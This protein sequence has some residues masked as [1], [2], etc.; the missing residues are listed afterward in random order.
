MSGTMKG[1]LMGL[2]GF[3][4]GLMVSPQRVE[5]QA[6]ALTGPLHHLGFAVKDADKAAR[7]FAELFEVKTPPTRAVRDIPWGPD[8]PGKKMHVKV[9]SFMH[10]GIMWEMLEGVDGESPWGNHIAKHGESLH[11]I[12]IAV[13]NVPAARQKL[14][15]KGGKVTQEFSPQANYIDMEPR[16]P[17]TI[18]LLA[19]KMVAPPAAGA[20][21]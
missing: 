9:A 4:L 10:N 3:G 15:A 8:F 14:L 21:K 12:G 13:P 18:E 6:P 7:E 16:W 1:L 17:F 11:H 2:V 20:A 5:G 19:Q